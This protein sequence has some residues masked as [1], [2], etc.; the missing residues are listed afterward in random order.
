MGAKR[1]KVNL[2]ASAPMTLRWIQTGVDGG[3]ISEQADELQQ[4]QQWETCLA[5]N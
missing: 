5:L 1:V 4:Q 2:S 3:R